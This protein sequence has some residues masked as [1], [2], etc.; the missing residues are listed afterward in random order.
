MSIHLPD[1]QLYLAAL[2]LASNCFRT[3]GF[4]SGVARSSRVIILTL[5]PPAKTFRPS[6]PQ[7]PSE[8][9]GTGDGSHP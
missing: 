2:M 6:H 5:L 9:R 8:V 1:F 4:P 7:R 3:I